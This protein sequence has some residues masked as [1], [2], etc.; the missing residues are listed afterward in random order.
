[1]FYNIFKIIGN[2]SFILNNNNNNN[3]T[4]N[5]K[6]FLT[7]LQLLLPPSKMLRIWYNNYGYISSIAYLNL[8]QNFQYR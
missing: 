5:W 2:Y 1:M 7:S 8:I 6:E 3:N 4:I